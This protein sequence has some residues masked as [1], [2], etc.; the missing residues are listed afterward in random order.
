MK[1]VK[2][3]TMVQMLSGGEMRMPDR[4]RGTEEQE[5]ALAISLR[6]LF[7][8]LN[9]SQADFGHLT[10]CYNEKLDARKWGENQLKA[11]FFKRRISQRVFFQVLV[12][13]APFLNDPKRLKAV[14]KPVD[15]GFWHQP[16]V[17][18]EK[19][20]RPRKPNLQENK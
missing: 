10:R 6:E 7:R 8:V 13:L 4:L 18:T 5:T 17:Q 2:H 16:I 19:P 20:P 15:H 1:Q 11:K 14:N 12:F 3:P 9:V